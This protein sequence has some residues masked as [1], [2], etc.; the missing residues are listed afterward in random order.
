[1][2]CEVHVAPENGLSGTAPSVAPNTHAARAEYFEELG[3]LSSTGRYAR[4]HFQKR[5]SRADGRVMLGEAAVW[6]LPSLLGVA[7]FPH[8][9]L[10]PWML[11]Y[12][13]SMLSDDISD[14]DHEPEGT[15]V[16]GALLCRAILRFSEA[17]GSPEAVMGWFSD[18]QLDVADEASAE[19]SSQA[20]QSVRPADYLSAGR[21][22]AHLRVLARAIASIRQES[23]LSRR[24][25]NGVHEL[26][27]AVQLLDDLTDLARDYEAGRGTPLLRAT[28]RYVERNPLRED[29]GWVGQSLLVGA[30]CSGGAHASLQASGALLESALQSFNGAPDGAGQLFVRDLC[31]RVKAAANEIAEAGEAVRRFAISSPCDQPDAPSPSVPLLRARRA[32][33]GVACSQ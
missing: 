1:M 9:F 33:D 20:I 30:L 4:A 7:T 12:G 29:L 31:W 19:H 25:E 3:R 24:E 28:L 22:N 21:K 17:V 27:A 23:S 8:R 32:L 5:V 11:L 15:H 18:S 16:A 2:N 6:L 13:Y 10:T 14:G 26:C